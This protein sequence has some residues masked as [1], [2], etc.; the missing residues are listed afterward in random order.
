[1]ERPG[2]ALPGHRS[3]QDALSSTVAPRRRAQ[4]LAVVTQ[5]PGPT[6]AAVRQCSRQPVRLTPPVRLPAATVAFDLVSVQTT[7]TS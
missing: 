1:M 3:L 2:I 6:A 7:L 4:M 5:R